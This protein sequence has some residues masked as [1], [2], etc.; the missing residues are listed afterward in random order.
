[1]TSLKQ[2]LNE[3]LTEALKTYILDNCNLM[4]IVYEINS[5]GGDL[6]DLKYYS[7]DEEFFDIFFTEDKMELVR[8]LSFGNY[9]FSDDYVKFN[10]Y[11]NLESANS[12]EI[13]KQL[14]DSISEIV[15]S[16]IGLYGDVTLDD[17]IAN[18]LIELI[19]DDEKIS[20]MTPQQFDEFLIEEYGVE[21]LKLDFNSMNSAELVELLE[22]NTDMEIYE[23]TPSFDDMIQQI[24]SDL[25][26]IKVEDWFI[27]FR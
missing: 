27:L 20:I 6:E 5:Y 26:L 11:G 24:E 19:E 13:N 2:L 22:E 17:D 3:K 15:E 14:E 16:L 9:N 23:L 4:E 8:A 18:G 10:A 7:N 21:D 12:F 25:Q 1:M